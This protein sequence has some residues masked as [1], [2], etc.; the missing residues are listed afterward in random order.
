MIEGQRLSAQESI[1][2]V[3]LEL[4]ERARIEPVTDTIIVPGGQSLDVLMRP[5]IIRIIDTKNKQLGVLA[6]VATVKGRR[7][8]EASVR[9]QW[10]D[11]EGEH[12]YPGLFAGKL[13]DQAITY[14]DAASPN[15]PIDCLHANWDDRS[16][17]TVQYRA[18][19]KR[20][21]CRLD[22][23]AARRASAFETWTGALALRNG[24]DYILGDVRHFYT[25]SRTQVIE[26]DFVRKPSRRR[27]L[28]RRS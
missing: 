6:T 14:F 2:V 22:P 18:A 7:V 25:E 15:G 23:P 10:E 17:N 21:L 27:W 1:G 13:L 5:D 4:F 28:F 20:N 19:L 12:Q 24:F 26:A 11:E 16:I 9:T 3:P 8:L